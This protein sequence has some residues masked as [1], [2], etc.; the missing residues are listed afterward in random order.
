[1]N[2]VEIP[3]SAGYVALVD[4]ED[5]ARVLAFKWTAQKNR[6]TV[7][8]FRKVRRPDG[9][10][11]KLALHKFLT[12]YERTDHRNGDGLDNRRSNLRD[13]TAGENSWNRRRPSVSTSGFKGVSWHKHRS[14][15]QAYITGDGPR[16]HLGYFPTAEGAAHAYDAAARELHGEYATVNFPTPGERAA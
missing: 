12:G 16:R 8:A 6:R 3:L 5:A 2:V 4:A 1:M 10:R 13:A 7:Y 9:G 14:K 11:A 15:W